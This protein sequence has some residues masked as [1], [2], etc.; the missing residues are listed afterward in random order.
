MADRTEPPDGTS[1]DGDDDERPKTRS[2][3]RGRQRPPARTRRTRREKGREKHDDP[4]AFALIIE[5]RWDGS[6]PPTPERYALALRQWAALPGAVSAVQTAV[7]TSG[8][9]A[10]NDGQ[11]PAETAPDP[12]RGEES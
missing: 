2:G 10:P 9:G 8:S 3:G 11:P 4:R 5:R 12:E 7:D 1:Y 6:A